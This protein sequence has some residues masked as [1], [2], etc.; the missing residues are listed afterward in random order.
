MPHAVKPIPDGYHSLTPALIVKDADAAIGWYQKA[1][2]AKLENRMTGPDGKSVSHAELRIGDSL[3]FLGDEQSSMGAKSPTS[4]G[5]THGSLH[6]YTLDADAAYQRAVDAGAK[7][8]LPPSD[9]PWGDRY[10][11][12][13]DPFGHEWGVATRKE[14]LTAAEMERR[15]REWSIRLSQEARPS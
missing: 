4:L 11:R 1:L 3:L 2:G 8:I 13:R 15:T 7:P 9:M 6:L 5:G 14:E 10:G 12:F